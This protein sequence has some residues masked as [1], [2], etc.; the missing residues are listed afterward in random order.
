MGKVQRG[1]AGKQALELWLLAL[2]M[3]DSEGLW[4]CY[5]FSKTGALSHDMRTL[6]WV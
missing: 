4:I 1:F 2:A 5:D 6:G 3:L